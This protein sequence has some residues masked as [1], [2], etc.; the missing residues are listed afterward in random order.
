MR[1]AEKL[2]WKR[3]IHLPFFV[4]VQ[5][6]V[7][8]FDHLLGVFILVNPVYVAQIGVEFLVEAKLPSLSFTAQV[9]PGRRGRKPEDKLSPDIKKNNPIRRILTEIGKDAMTTVAAR[10]YGLPTAEWRTGGSEI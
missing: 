4:L 2:D 1:V 6:T 9:I 7:T 5:L 10:R 8:L 3:L